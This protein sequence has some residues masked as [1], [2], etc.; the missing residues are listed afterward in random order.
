M[1]VSSA[2]AV[3][4]GCDSSGCRVQTT[5]A[6]AASSA[7]TAGSKQRHNDKGGQ[8]GQELEL[9][10]FQCIGQYLNLLKR[11]K[12]NIFHIMGYINISAISRIELEPN[13]SIL[14]N[15]TSKYLVYIPDNEWASR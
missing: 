5:L 13:I 7:C 11:L 6:V 12:L 2:G 14:G 1:S 8:S 3:A 9:A 4:G 10:A 15:N